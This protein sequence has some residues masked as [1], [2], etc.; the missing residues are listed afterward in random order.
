MLTFPIFFRKFLVLISTFVLFWL[1]TGTGQIAQAISP[2]ADTFVYLPEV[3]K[4]NLTSKIVYTSARD[5]N[6]E[7]YLL[8]FKRNSGDA[9]AIRL[10][11]Q[12]EPEWRPNLSLDGTKIVF[13]SHRSGAWDIYS[14]NSDG[15]QVVQL[16]NTTQNYEPDW[17]PDGSKI[18][19]HSYRD[20]YNAI[21]VMNADGSE[22]TRLTNSTL[23]T[24]CA[25]WTPDGTKVTYFSW[26]PEPPYTGRI[27]TAN[28]DGSHTAI[29]LEINSV[30]NMDW[31]PDGRYLAISIPDYPDLAL[32]DATLATLTYIT[33]PTNPATWKNDHVS[34]S[35]DGLFLVFA[36]VTQDAGQDLYIMRP[37]GSDLKKITTAPATDFMPDWSK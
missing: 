4:H 37:D 3:L 15:S 34:W 18:V 20:G 28:P 30:E 9:Y 17:S 25:T 31:S 23:E 6:F 1:A 11:D 21:Y 29:L 10:T 26:L 16:T 24:C 7:I 13:E 27:Y 14:M 33:P 12:A 35:P 2:M 36:G 32:Y 8:D 22:Q 5:G 19:F